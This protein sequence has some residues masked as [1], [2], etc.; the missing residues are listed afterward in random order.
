MKGKNEIF[1]VV[2]GA[3]G[4]LPLAASRAAGRFAAF[5]LARGY[6]PGQAGLSPTD[7]RPLRPNLRPFIFFMLPKATVDVL[8]FQYNTLM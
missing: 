1:C 4:V 8:M 6:L 7:D 2:V 5:A 3:F